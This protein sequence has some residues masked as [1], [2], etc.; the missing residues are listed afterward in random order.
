MRVAVAIRT[1][2]GTS[3]IGGGGSATSPL[4]TLLSAI[5]ISMRSSTY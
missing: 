2:R 5:A 1:S 3:R 4:A